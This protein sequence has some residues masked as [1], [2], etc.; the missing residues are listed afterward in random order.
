MRYVIIPGINGSGEGHWQSI[1][2]DEWGAYASRISPFSWDVPD[3]DDWCQAIDKAV[4]EDLSTDMVLVAHSLGCHAAT[5]WVARRRPDIG[6]VFLVAPP[7]NAGANFPAEASTFTAVKAT[8]L[9]VP[10]LVVFSDDDPYCS[11]DVALRLTAGWQLDH[12]SVG[13]AGHI[14][15]ASRL[16][17]WD[18]G[19]ALLTAFTAGTR[20]P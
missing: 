9:H 7:D 13:S 1:W 6:G 2:Q 16:G 5:S 4:G 18:F 19:R 3:L 17:R 8:P 15:S 11:P 10:G 20:R 12:V 14:N